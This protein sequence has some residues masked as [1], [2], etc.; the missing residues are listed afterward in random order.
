MNGLSPII[1][2]YDGDGAFSAPYMR[3][4]TLMD[5]SFV[6]G[7]QYRLEIVHERSQ[8]SHAHY[9]AC[10]NSAWQSLPETMGDR[11]P[12]AEHLRKYALVQAGYRDERSI[13]CASRAEAL[14]VAAFVKPMDTYAIV[15]T[16]EAVVRVFTAQSQSYRAMGKTQFAASKEAVL[17]IVSEMIGTD[18]AALR[19]SQDDLAGA[20]RAS[21]AKEK[22]A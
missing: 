6:I 11:F 14:R 22:A 10:I 18:V 19:L 5:K 8:A 17:A 3:L 9:F 15:T 16:S 2:R 4:A 1:L 13:V 7:E 20:L 21:L 12:T